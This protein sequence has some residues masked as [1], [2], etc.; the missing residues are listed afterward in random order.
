M[1][2]K[3][4]RTWRKFIDHGRQG[5]DRSLLSHSLLATPRV[6]GPERPLN[7]QVVTLIQ[8]TEAFTL[9]HHGYNMLEFKRLVPRFVL[10]SLETRK[11][12]TQEK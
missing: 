3:G 12:K 5:G 2:W 7:K 10:M 9:I 6:P 11:K 4:P 1:E 8:T